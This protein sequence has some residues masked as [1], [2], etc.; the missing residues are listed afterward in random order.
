MEGKSEAE[1]QA[2]DA[3][4]KGHAEANKVCDEAWARARRAYDEA[5]KQA[6]IVHNEA[7][8]IAF[9]KEAKKAGDEA[10]KN[11]I[12]QAKKLREAIIAE[13]MVVFR[14]SYDQATADYLETTAKS[15]AAIKDADETYN[16]AKKQ[17]DIV[18]KEAKKRAVDKQAK[19]EADEAYKKAIEQAKQV[20]DEATRT[21]R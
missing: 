10:H 1:T 18:Y 16:E 17:A 20:R 21:L 8:K 9:D 3:Q 11:T 19:K 12:E 4:T 5:K 7:S 15:K 13:A 6:D 2:L 14:T